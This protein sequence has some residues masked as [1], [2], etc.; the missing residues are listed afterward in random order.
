MLIKREKHITM[1]IIPKNELNALESILFGSEI[2][3]MNQRN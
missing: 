2:K 3:V 1:K